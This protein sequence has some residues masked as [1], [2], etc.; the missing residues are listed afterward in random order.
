MVG[1]GGSQ[2]HRQLLI[3]CWD[4]NGLGRAVFAMEGDSV[5]TPCP[6]KSCIGWQFRTV[7]S[8]QRCI[9]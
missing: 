4:I 2:L 9:K 1:L 5:D 7:T 3:V 8:L 6:P